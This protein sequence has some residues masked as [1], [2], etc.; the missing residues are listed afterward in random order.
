MAKYDTHMF[1]QAYKRIQRDSRSF[2]GVGIIFLH[3]L[4][5]Q[6][7][8]YHGCRKSYSKIYE[9]FLFPE[10][11]PR[12]YTHSI[13]FFTLMFAAVG[14]NP[15]NSWKTA[16]VFFHFFYN[17]FILLDGKRW[18]RDC[19]CGERTHSQLMPRWK[20]ILLFFVRRRN[21]NSTH[22]AS[23]VMD[24][25]LKHQDTWNGDVGSSTA[26]AVATHLLA[27]W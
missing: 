8:A 3:L 15:W 1:V 18:G 10:K 26:T 9:D 12:S 23:D 27:E 24:T 17:L 4:Q 22:P 16:S 25:C 19:R 11:A 20:I 7:R 13:Y 6:M 14:W 2:V 5:S 21:T